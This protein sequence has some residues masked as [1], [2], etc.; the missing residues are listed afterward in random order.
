VIDGG[1][2]YKDGDRHLVYF[3]LNG[4][5]YRAVLKRTQDTR[6]NYESVYVNIDKAVC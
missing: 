2:V 5:R 6:K 3:W 1:E 4:K